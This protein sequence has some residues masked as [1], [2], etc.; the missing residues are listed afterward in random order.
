[1]PVAEIFIPVIDRP[2]YLSGANLWM[3]LAFAIVGFQ[4]AFNVRANFANLKKSVLPQTPVVHSKPS[5]IRPFQPS[6]GDLK[7]SREMQFERAIKIVDTACTRTLQSA[8]YHKAARE[9]L[10]ATDYA[11]HCMFGELSAVMPQF[12]PA[13]RTI[14]KSDL[15]AL[16]PNPHVGQDAIEEEEEIVNAA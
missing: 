1:M 9:K 12:A 3:P 5:N 2:G 15:N 8:Y 10:D 7:L 13:D 11:M 6:P 4:I 14:L 16:Q